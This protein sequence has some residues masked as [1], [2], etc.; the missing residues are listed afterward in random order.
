MSLEA[1]DRLSNQE[2]V[3]GS[4]LIEPKLIGQVLGKVSER[5]FLDDAYRQ[6]FLAIRAQFIS[7]KPVDPVTVRDKLGSREEWGKLLL[8]IMDDTPT[9][10]NVWEYVSRMQEQAR[11]VQGRAQHPTNT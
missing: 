4:M 1:K 2:A 9:A 3:L 10:A 6:I 5:D 7:G 11:V 8:Q